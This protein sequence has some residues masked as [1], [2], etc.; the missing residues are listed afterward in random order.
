MASVDSVRSVVR[1]HALPPQHL[2]GWRRQ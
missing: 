2:F 1:R